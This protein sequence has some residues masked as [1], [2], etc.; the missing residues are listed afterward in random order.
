MA[1]LSY[2]PESPIRTIWAAGAISAYNKG[3]LKGN[4]VELH[5]IVSSNGAHAAASNIMWPIGTYKCCGCNEMFEMDPR[6]GKYAYFS[7]CKYSDDSM[8]DGFMCW[9]CRTLN[10]KSRDYVIHVFAFFQVPWFFKSMRADSLEEYVKKRLRI[11]MRE[12]KAAKVIQS[13]WRSIIS[14]PKHP[15]CQRCLMAE[16]NELMTF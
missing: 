11:A 1:L 3:N 8:H 12:W 4:S 5:D 15:A 13:Y 7:R 2:A 14:D 10:I 9:S 6:K 16:A